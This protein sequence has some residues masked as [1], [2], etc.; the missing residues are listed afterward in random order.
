M[1]KRTLLYVVVMLILLALAVSAGQWDKSTA[2]LQQHAAEISAWL[3]KQASEVK[4][5]GISTGT[6]LVH[7]ADSLLSWS[8]TKHIPD[9]RDL[10]ILSEKTGQSC[11]RLRQGWYLIQAEKSDGNSRTTLIPIRY[12]LNFNQLSEEKPFPANPDISS[13]VQISE[14]KTAYPIKFGGQEICWLQASGPVQSA[15]LQRLKLGAWLLFFCVFFS[16]LAQAG[17]VVSTR[18]GALAGTALVTIVSTILLWLNQQTGFTSEQFGA[19]PIFA[20]SFE[21]TSLIGNSV[22]DWLIHTAVLVFVMGFFHRMGSFANGGNNDIARTLGATQ[23]FGLAAFSYLLAML[24]ILIGTETIRQLVFH[25]RAGFDLDHVLN[26]GLLG[27]LALVGVVALMAGLFLFSHRMGQSVRSFQLSRR[28]RFMAIATAGSAFAVLCFVLAPVELN[29]L[30][31]IGFGLLYILALDAFVH[32]NGAGFGWA[33]C[34]LVLF[35]LF[36]STQLYRFNGLRDKELRLSYAQA[37]AADRD[38]SLAESLLPKIMTAIQS[39]S[40]SIGRFL[41]PYPFKAGAAEL[42]DY[43]N[44]IVFE[45]NYLFQHYRLG[46]YAFDKGNQPILLGQTLGYEQV[47]LGNWATA[48]PVEGASSIRFGN[49]S[50]GAFRYMLQL[51]VFRMGDAAQP[52]TVYLFF[53]RDHPAPSPTFS[54]LFFN[55]PLKNLSQLPRYDFSISKNGRLTVDQGL[56][57][58]TALG[59]KLPNGG[60]AE[61]ESSTRSDAVAKSADG[62]TLAAVGHKVGGWL[63]QVYLFSIIFTLAALCL[64][65]LAFA[66]SWLGFLPAEY[67]FR[68]SASGSLARRIHFWNVTLLAVSFVVVGYLTYQHFTRSARDAE[69][70]DF[71]FRVTALLTNLKNQSLNSGLAGD[72]LSRALPQS[73]ATIA[74]S[75]GMDAQYYDPSGKLVFS[76]QEALVELGILPSKMNPAALNFLKK[77]P[78]SERVEQEESAGLA[79]STQ[80]RALQNGEGKLLGFLG[81]PYHEAKGNSGAE[82]SDFIGMLASLYVFLLLIAFGVTFL[83][84]RSITR[85]VSLLSEKVQELRLEDKNEPLAYEGDSGDEISQLIGQYNRMVSKL[86][87]SKIQLVKLEREGAWREMARQVAHDIKNPLTTMKLSMQQLERLSG[88]PEQAAAYL[89]KAITRLIEQIDSLAQI[90][91]EFSMFA[92]LDIKVKND[93]VINEVVESVHDLFSEQKQ[94]ALSLTLPNE[95]FH[96]LGD[97][98]HLIR[99]FNNLV[100]NAIQAIPSDRQGQIK[101]SLSRQGNLSVIQIS[102]NGG[103]IPPEIRERV[104]EP[105]FTTKTSGSGLGLAICKKIIE[106]H[107]GD[108]RFETRDNEG[109]DF[110]VEIPLTAVG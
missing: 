40:A 37:L 22:G 58:M 59:L 14:S 12:Q 28:Q 102:D 109:T 83:L 74:V 91:S 48:K 29:M 101:V 82:V 98:N 85:P 54:Q 4:N 88:N 3:D 64:L 71:N 97:K 92:N 80:Y 99:V 87:S 35:S 11:Y 34:W 75:L 44:R 27:F 50:D 10:K 39:D 105:N 70:N 20:Q 57:N 6:V 38:T 8:N 51:P 68:L 53:D 5:T 86:E 61:Y 31:V 33:M 90:A 23:K 42:R 13:N 1:F 47:V 21:K 108:I 66:N 94:V 56:A 41:K 46:V 32:W 25:S 2:L 43:L 76:T 63:K 18:L 107:D 26:L 104:F 16:L 72:S 19:L 60:S 84:A 15:W 103:G 79:Y 89:R 62:Q 110:F 55:S 65:A 81:V 69:R 78:Q 77:N 17:R 45:E 96:I 36:A 73:L 67:E 93:V 106:A 24:S 30:W 49:D 7:R 52:A 95:R 9:K 100:I